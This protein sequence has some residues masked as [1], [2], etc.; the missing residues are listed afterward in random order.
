MLLADL[1]STQK[2]I[3][4]QVIEKDTKRSQKN[5]RAASKTWIFSG[6]LV[7]DH[8]VKFLLFLWRRRVFHPNVRSVPKNLA[9]TKYV[10]TL[11]LVYYCLRSLFII[12]QWRRGSRSISETHNGPSSKRQGIPLTRT[13][14][15]L[16]LLAGGVLFQQKAVMTVPSW[17][18][19]RKQQLIPSMW[20][21]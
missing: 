9:H 19:Q 17:T 6:D 8:Y 4:L 10:G 15:S 5:F 21:Q 13:G 3:H 20:S 18:R 7:C 11:L 2:S 1:K 14:A 12:W 16:A